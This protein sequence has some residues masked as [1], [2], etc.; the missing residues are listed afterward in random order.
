MVPQVAMSALYFI[1]S[2]PCIHTPQALGYGESPGWGVFGKGLA[3]LMGQCNSGARWN[4]HSQ[5]ILTTR[6]QGLIQEERHTAVV[7]HQ[8][9]VVLGK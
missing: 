9:C 7:S 4:L 2:L 8:K 6:C 3:R 5:V 1:A